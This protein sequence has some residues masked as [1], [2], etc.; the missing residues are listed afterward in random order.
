[1][2]RFI[3]L[4]ILWAFLS[5]AHLLSGRT[6]FQKEFSGRGTLSC[7]LVDAPVGGGSETVG[8]KARFELPQEYRVLWTTAGANKPE[9]L[10]QLVPDLQRIRMARTLAAGVFLPFDGQ[11]WPDGSVLLV[12]RTSR[13][14]LSVV[15]QVGRKF[16]ATE[17]NVNLI[18]GENTRKSE[19]LRVFAAGQ[20]GGR[21]EK[22]NLSLVLDG[23]RG[24][25]VFGYDGKSWQHLWLESY[26]PFEKSIPGVG[27]II[28]TQTEFPVPKGF[29]VPSERRRD[30]PEMK[31][32]MDE[33]RADRKEWANIRSLHRHELFLI[34]N[35]SIERISIFKK[36]SYFDPSQSRCPSGFRVFDALVV[37]D[38]IYLTFLEQNLMRWARVDIAA[39]GVTARESHQEIANEFSHSTH[40]K[41]TLS[42]GKGNEEILVELV[43]SGGKESVYLNEKKY[44]YWN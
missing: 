26:P 32:L 11:V 9:I 38:R 28:A 21:L 3:I 27:K 20:L 44:G 14:V 25:E 13:D 16:T 19:P 12:F 36:L 40:S 18:V 8:P 39:T 2:K 29:E 5:D 37:G 30:A 1:M 23:S 31:A 17:S 4:S 42:L 22:T 7:E 24:R 10:W 15:L 41:A 33:I 6:L 35:G 43:G 34:K